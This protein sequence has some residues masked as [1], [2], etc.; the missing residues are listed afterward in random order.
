MIYA[1]GV[2]I[3]GLVMI[4]AG[5][6]GMIRAQRRHIDQ[7]RKHAAQCTETNLLLME[8]WEVTERE[9]ASTRA[10]LENYRVL[11]VYVPHRMPYRGEA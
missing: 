2:I 10:E 4:I 8:G 9:L 5:L 6:V 7:W 11:A 1:S 3:V